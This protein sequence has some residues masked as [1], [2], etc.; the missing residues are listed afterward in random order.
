MPRMTDL[1]N[2]RES[3]EADPTV[4]AMTGRT[5]TIVEIIKR[6]ADTLGV[7]DLH[8]TVKTGNISEEIIL[9]SPGEVLPNT[10]VISL[11]MSPEGDLETDMDQMD[12]A[13]MVEMLPHTEVI[14]GEVFHQT[15]EDTE[16]T[17][18]MTITNL[19]DTEENPVALLT[20]TT[21]TTGETT[22]ALD[23]PGEGLW[24]IRGET[25][26]SPQLEMDNLNSAEDQHQGIIVKRI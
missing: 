12:L 15:M 10:E 22:R 11:N 21:T 1:T 9:E 2:S 20:D 26:D 19:R 5:M 3:T 17:N 7:I 25:P 13:V 14:T 4:S 23:L 24:I 8:A 6:V 18:T 16:G